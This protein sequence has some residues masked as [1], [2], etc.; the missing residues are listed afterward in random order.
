MRYVLEVILFVCQISVMLSVKSIRVFSR[1]ANQHCRWAETPRTE[2]QYYSNGQVL[3]E[4]TYVNGIKEGRWK[5]WHQYGQKYQEGEYV[6]GKKHGEWE[7]FY[8]NGEMMEL[9]KYHHD[10]KVGDWNYWSYNGNYN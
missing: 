3:D 10:E 2:K 8:E 5:Y 4:G 9:G 6:G 7:T 1:I